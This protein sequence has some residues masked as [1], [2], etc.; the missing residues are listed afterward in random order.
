MSAMGAYYA[1]VA[2]LGSGLAAH[3]PTLEWLV[4][5]SLKDRGTGR[6]RALAVAFIKAAVT[7]N[8]AEVKVFDHQTSG[9]NNGQNFM[10]D[11]VRAA[12]PGLQILPGGVIEAQPA[13]AA[14]LSHPN[15]GV[16]QGALRSEFT[17][18]CRACLQHGISLDWMMG[19][20]KASIVE[21]VMKL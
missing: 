7:T 19:V 5:H 12:A 11:A 3:L 16:L 17:S 9:W 2:N 13:Y 21:S 1:A 10:I 18:L 15:H 14:S 8:G 6:T 4:S 20:L